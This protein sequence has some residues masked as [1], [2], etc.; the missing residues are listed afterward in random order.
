[1]DDLEI[2]EELIRL[3]K[4]R[5][6]A[7]LV[8]V[9]ESSGSAPRKAGAKMLVSSDGSVRGSV[10]GGKI[11][12]AAIEAALQSLRDGNTRTLSFTLTE[13]NGFVCGGKVLIYVEPIAPSPRLVIVGAGHIGQAVA[14]I[15]KLTGIEVVLADP[16][17]GS[18]ESKVRSFSQADMNIQLSELDQL[19]SI[20]SDSM[21]LIATRTHDDDFL[22]VE[23]ALHTSACYIGLLGSRRKKT[24]LK[25]YLAA[26]G[27]TEDSMQRIVTPVGLDISAQTPEEIAVSIVAQLIQRRRDGDNT[28]VSNSAGSRSFPENGEE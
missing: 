6:P 8:M 3:K 10:G 16:Y 2:F 14:K 28:C 1:M 5:E 9:V 11:E 12:A 24:A 25:S 26:Q 19:L 27:I 7:A 21:L 13:D 20:T 15:A 4:T 22:A 23:R 18:T 17:G